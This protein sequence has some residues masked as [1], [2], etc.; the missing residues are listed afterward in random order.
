MGQI[1]LQLA[2]ASCFIQTKRLRAARAKV[3]FARARWTFLVA[4]L[5]DA[6][7]V[8]GYVFGAGGDAVLVVLGNDLAFVTGRAHVD[9]ALA[10]TAAVALVADIVVVCKGSDV[11]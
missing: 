5:A 10:G 2:L 3:E 7:N 1:A 6:I 8:N 9:S 11:S 4:N